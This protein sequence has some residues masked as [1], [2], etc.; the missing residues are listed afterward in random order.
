VRINPKGPSIQSPPVILVSFSGIDGAGKSTQIANLCARM[1]EACLRVKLITF[2]DDVARLKRI[3]ESAGHKLFRGDQGVGTPE[4]PIRR[5]DKNVASPLMTL[6]RLGFY[7]LDAL[8]LRLVVAKAWRSSAD[9]V[10]FDRYIYDELANLN[11]R[12]PAARLYS[13]AILKLVPK[14]QIS[15]LL[16][17]DPAEA[18]ARKPEYPLEFVRFSRDSYLGLTRLVGGITVIPPMPLEQTKAAVLAC[19]LRRRE[20]VAPAGAAPVGNLSKNTRS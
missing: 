2:W 13:R 9:F 20:L 8:S 17:A 19:V 5:R 4:V 15:F 6:L 12:N 10:I 16:D 11:L 14:P 7:F 3:R 1:Q 18:C